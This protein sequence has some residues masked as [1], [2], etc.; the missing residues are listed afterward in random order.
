MEYQETDLDKVLKH[1]IE[2]GPK[3]VIKIIYYTLLS[4]SFMHNANVI[5]RDIKP[6]N[7]LVT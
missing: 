2:F 4:L 1:K 6:A 7:I 3:H 5:H